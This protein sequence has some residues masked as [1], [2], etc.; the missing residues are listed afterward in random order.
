MVNYAF[1]N[2][3]S[4][5]MARVAGTNLAI[6]RKAA[7]E[8]GVFIKNRQIDT[9]ISYLEKVAEGKAPLPYGK[10]NKKT[11]HHAPFGP[12]GY[13]HRTSLA[14]INLLRSLKNNAQS[15]GINTSKL[16]VIHAAAHKGA[17]LFHPGGMERKNTH[18][19]IV[20][21]EKEVKNEKRK[22]RSGKQ[23]KK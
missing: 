3:D 5:T 9:A 16:F 4:K 20:A 13:P 11:A 19:E 22:A 7:R 12:S 1:Q 23:D 17:R 18:V 21:Q 10:F 14:I 6:S 8:I 2:Y 15:K